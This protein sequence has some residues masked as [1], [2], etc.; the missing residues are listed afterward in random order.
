MR[1]TLK[2]LRDL[3]LIKMVALV[4]LFI[5]IFGLLVAS[6][7][8]GSKFVNIIVLIISII[9]GVICGYVSLKLLE[10]CDIMINRNKRVLEMYINEIDE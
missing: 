10:E 8:F 6:Y 4:M 7:L 1:K 3:Y 5:T 2:N 9:V